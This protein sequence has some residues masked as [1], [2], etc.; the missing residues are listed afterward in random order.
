MGVLGAIVGAV[1]GFAIGILFVE[2]IFANNQ[3]WPDVVP[4]VL[5]ILGALAGSRAVRGIRSRVSN[6]N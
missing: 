1:A 2:V 4:F 5:A 6:P 3:S